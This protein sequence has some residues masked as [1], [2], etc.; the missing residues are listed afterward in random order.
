MARAQ[1][2]DHRKGPEDGGFACLRTI[3]NIHGVTSHKTVILILKSMVNNLFWFHLYESLWT[4]KLFH[5]EIS[6]DLL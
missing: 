1:Y 3:R 4:V 2:N 5:T 6:Y